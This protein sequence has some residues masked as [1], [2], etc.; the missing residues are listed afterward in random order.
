MLKR[1][2][3][4]KPAFLIGHSMGSLNIQTFLTVNPGLNIAGVIHSSPFFDF[5]PSTGPNYLKT[6]QSKIAMAVG[7]EMPINPILQ[8][9]WLSHD[10]AYWARL[11]NIDGTV[12]PIV[13]GGIVYSMLTSVKDVQD[14]TKTMK[15]PY[16]LLLAGKDKI[17]DNVAARAWDRNTSTPASKKVNKQY[18]ESYHQIWKEPQYV[19][20]IYGDTYDFIT[21]ILNEG[22][23]LNWT[24][25]KTFNVGRPLSAS[26]PPFKRFV[27]G[28]LIGAYLLL[29]FA[30]WIGV[31]LFSS[32]P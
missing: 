2:R 23:D 19:Q 32:R 12:A 24:S 6:F 20:R 21:K 22:G 13:S 28:L 4:D 7:E 5:H 29:G 26:N 17:I 16:L 30:L 11:M 14:N 8:G 27:A 1:F 18:G 25:I 31:K 9:H 10:K 15:L 3:T